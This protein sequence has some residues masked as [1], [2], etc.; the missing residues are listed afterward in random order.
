MRK[1]CK[2][3]K[4]RPVALVCFY[5]A[6]VAVYVSLVAVAVAAHLPGCF[7]VQSPRGAGR[8]DPEGTHCR[9]AATPHRQ[10]KTT[11]QKEATLKSTFSKD[12]I[13]V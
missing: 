10:T 12:V 2:K 13:I 7:L 5:L 3:K 8:G 9:R 1:I 11:F 6:Q 4:K